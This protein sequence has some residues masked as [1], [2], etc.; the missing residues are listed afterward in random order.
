M[1]IQHAKLE[2]E[3]ER[4]IFKYIKVD[5][6]IQYDRRIVKEVFEQEFNKSRITLMQEENMHQQIKYDRKFQQSRTKLD[7]EIDKLWMLMKRM[8][9]KSYNRKKKK[10]NYNVQLIQRLC[11]GKES[12]QQQHRI[13]KPGELKA[14]TEIKQQQKRMNGQ[15]Q[16]KV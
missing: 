3:E 9:K 4:V 8:S 2:V 5:R 13:W 15:L 7:D 16:N 12:K 1:H 6:A 11:L 10:T 14:T